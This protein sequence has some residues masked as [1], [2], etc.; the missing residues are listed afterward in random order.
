MEKIRISWF[1]PQK[2]FA[3]DNSLVALGAV[4][5][6]C[7]RFQNERVESKRANNAPLFW[8][9]LLFR[10][11]VVWFGHFQR[12]L[13]VTRNGT[14]RVISK[15]QGSLFAFHSF[16]NCLLCSCFV[17]ESHLYVDKATV[18]FLPYFV[19]VLRTKVKMK[20]YSSFDLIG[21]ITFCSIFWQTKC[22]W[23]IS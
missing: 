12:F 18:F 1:A 22:K 19:T 11:I 16:S 20:C 13:F 14:K 8:R 10:F 6:G 2:T 23:A 9:F 21:K 7:S 15:G 17:Y 4:K 3:E 5:L